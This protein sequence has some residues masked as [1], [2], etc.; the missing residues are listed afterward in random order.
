[1]IA[2]DGPAGSGKSTTARAVA[3]KLGFA[4]LDSGALYRAVTLAALDAGGPVSGE[5]IV[6]LATSLP[7]RLSVVD[8]V[9]RPE[10]AGVDV[11]IPIRT[12]R[13]TDAVS[14]VAA[15]P[16]VRRWVDAELRAAAGRHPN[17][18]VIDGR[19]IGTVVFPDA[20]LKIFLT[21][22]Q[23][24]RARRRSRETGVIKDDA[25]AG[26]QQRLAERDQAD[27]GRSVAPLV[28][29][30]DAVHVDTTHMSFAEQVEKI[31]SLGQKAFG[32]NYV[33]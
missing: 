18:V 4:H 28:A 27:S 21:A 16:A 15:L 19:D 7:V 17:G 20:G 5:V 23:E 29:A 22:S 26:I 12:T 13:V 11:S 25:I 31:A 32:G 6:G 2:I 14:A 9:F 8:H 3:D 30:P 10:V 24:E 1:V 33:A